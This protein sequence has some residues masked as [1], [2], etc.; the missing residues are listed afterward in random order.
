MVKNLKD[1]PTPKFND[2]ERQLSKYQGLNIV[3]SYQ[4][5]WVARSIN[6]LIETAK[7]KGLKIKTTELK[8]AKEAQNAPSVYSVFNL[9][10][11]GKILADHY[12]SNKRFQNII[13][14]EIK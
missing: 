12:I 11:N 3:Y 9:I 5:P 14:R 4:C 13:E 2:W 6:E 7:E 10:Y 1:G 8:N